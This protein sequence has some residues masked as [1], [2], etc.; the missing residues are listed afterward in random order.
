[1][2]EAQEPVRIIKH[3][4]STSQGV[5]KL[6]DELK[7]LRDVK[8]KH[9]YDM[10][11]IKNATDKA[12]DKIAENTKELKAQQEEKATIINEIKLSR[13]KLNM[14]EQENKHRQAENA[15]ILE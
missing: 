12:N 3:N 4:E 11:S 15:D 2:K 7:K 14:V 1:M 6:E 8:K 10:N 5:D 13:H 9:E